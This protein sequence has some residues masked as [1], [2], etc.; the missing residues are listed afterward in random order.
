MASSVL[1]EMQAHWV[2]AAMLCWLA[3]SMLI[4][5]ARGLV[6][7][8][9]SLVGWGVAYVGAHAA[10]PLLAPH[11]H[12]GASGSAVNEVVAF[13]LAFFV[14]LLLWAVVTRLVRLLV[15]ATPLSLP[16]R[17]LGAGFGAV[18][19]VLVLLLVAT[20]IGLTP[21]AGSHAW[22]Q[23]QCAAWLNG[24]LQGLKPWLPADLSRHLPA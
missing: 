10:Q 13:V 8:T 23:S 17:V 12:L 22:A 21:M 2:D 19:G 18:R 16:D 14:I 5:V 6:F 1:A 24:A 15:H 4:G 3:V 9:L 11:L 20:L 7:E